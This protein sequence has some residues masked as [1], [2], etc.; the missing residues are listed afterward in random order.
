MCMVY[1][2]KTILIIGRIIEDWS[3]PSYIY[4]HHFPLRY[5][6]VSGVSSACACFNFF[7]YLSME[8]PQRHMNFKDKL[9]Y[10]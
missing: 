6:S 4:I 8:Y 10:M 5:I 9:L 7:L 3:I 2:R 1:E